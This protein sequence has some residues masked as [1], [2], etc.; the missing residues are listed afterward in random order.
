[1]DYSRIEGQSSLASSINNELSTETSIQTEIIE[2]SYLSFRPPLL[3]ANFGS[4]TVLGLDNVLRYRPFTL[5]LYVSTNTSVIEEG[6]VRFNF[7]NDYPFYNRLISS[8]SSNPNSPT[9]L[10]T[11]K[12][13]TSDVFYLRVERG[14]GEDVQFGLSFTLP[15]SST[16]YCG[17]YSLPITGNVN[18][19][20][21]INTS[22]NQL[23]LC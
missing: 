3:D 6:W 1:M 20:I 2:N 10:E 4:F 5:N 12:C 19:Y 13:G 7:N 16:G 21:N 8:L 11:L 15:A 23:V 9:L 17:S 18:I 22:S 14:W